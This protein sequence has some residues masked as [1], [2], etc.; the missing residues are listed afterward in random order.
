MALCFRSEAASV[1]QDSALTL[2]IVVEEA[3][4]LHWQWITK[5]AGA[6]LG[7][8]ILLRAAPAQGGRESVLFSASTPVAS[9]EGDLK[10]KQAG[11]LSVRWE[12]QS[13]HGISMLALGPAVGLQYKLTLLTEREIEEERQG[14]L[15]ALEERVQGRAARRVQIAVQA[16]LRVRAEARARAHAAA[17]RVQCAL[18]CALATRRLRRLRRAK[19][20]M[21]EARV[22]Q[23]VARARQRRRPIRAA[24]SNLINGGE[25]SASRTNGDGDGDC[26]GDSGA[27]AS[28]RSGPA[29]VFRK[30]SELSVRSNEANRML[31][32]LEDLTE[33]GTLPGVWNG[34]QI[35][36]EQAWRLRRTCATLTQGIASLTAAAVAGG[37][38]T[39]LSDG[40]ASRVQKSLRALMYMAEPAHDW[41]FCKVYMHVD[42]EAI[43]LF[44]VDQLTQAPPLD[45]ASAETTRIALA[46]AHVAITSV[47]AYEFRLQFVSEA[48]VGALMHRA[49]K[50]P[51]TL[52]ALHFRCD[53]WRG[54]HTWVNGLILLTSRARALATDASAEACAS[55]AAGR[56]GDGDGDA[57]RCGGSGDGVG[58]QGSRLN[59][60]PKPPTHSSS[61]RVGPPGKTMARWAREQ[62]AKSQHV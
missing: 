50:P 55:D 34:L 42:D 5:E 49:P 54:L 27:A 11:T 36:P 26:G 22:L 14:K 23:R 2:P 39:A 57:N 41:F 62:L 28:G 60:S 10:L 3:A 35:D 43:V 32:L 7:F 15:R 17:V 47:E 13:W 31:Q 21:R 33:V 24:N 19:I 56:S 29:A 46:A 61:S 40:E 18:R 51:G 48:A 9:H 53:T 12:A 1:A 20:E 8:S 37:E 38:S 30:S 25:A 59:I 45:A 44:V 58:R 16:W 4:R 6:V 52:R